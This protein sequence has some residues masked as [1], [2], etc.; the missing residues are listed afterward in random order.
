MMSRFQKRTFVFL[1]ELLFLNP[2][3]FKLFS[4]ILHVPCFENLAS[5]VGLH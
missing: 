1:Y 4:L 5:A 2:K 3:L